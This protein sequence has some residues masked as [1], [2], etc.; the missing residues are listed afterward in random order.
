LERRVRK[1]EP[2]GHRARASSDL[3]VDLAVT[4]GA[5]AGKTTVLVDRF[6]AIARDPDV[7]PDRILAITFTKKAATEMKER[8]IRQFERSGEVA[9][10]RATEAAYISTI[11]GFAERILRERPFDARIDPA[12]GVLTDYDKELWIAEALRE[13]YERD[14][15]RAFAPRLKKTFDGGWRVFEL[16]REV[17]RLM[18]EG[19]K[20]A[21]C[22]A[23]L[24]GDDDRCVKHALERVRRMVMRAEQDMLECMRELHP[25][26]DGATFKSK[27]AMYEQSREYLQAVVACL[28]AKQAGAVPADCWSNTRFTGQIDEGER[29]AIKERLALIKQLAPVATFAR[30]DEEEALEREL[31]PLKRAIYGAAAEMDRSYAQHKRAIGALDFH[32]LQLRAAALLADNPSVRDEYAERFRH[33]LLDESQDTDA[34]QYGIIESLRTPRNTLFMVGDPKQAIYE[35]RG[36]NPDV[37]HAAVAK[38]PPEDRLQL[39]EN[40]RSRSEIISMINGFGTPLLADQFVHIDARADYGGQELAEPAVSVIYAEQRSLDEGRKRYEPVSAARPREAAAVAEELVRLLR[41][42]PLVRDPE[43]REVS[44]VPLRPRHIAILFRTRTAIPYFERAL[45]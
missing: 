12:F 22:E 45:A 30:W 1:I 33:I 5:G 19:P 28:K 37:F 4:A 6:V 23:D 15:L 38:L 10:R 27:K 31:L 40:F 13:M 17:A 41:A 14:E 18:R 36:A 29:E 11:H 35:F 21:R 39:P 7:G 42:A 34:L 2:S 25:M 3:G 9:L 8:A 26:L 43:S 20:E 16:V 24:I 44:W 32:D